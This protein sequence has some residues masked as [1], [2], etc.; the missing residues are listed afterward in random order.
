MESTRRHRF[1]C[2]NIFSEGWYN[3]DI[4][5]L[6]DWASSSAMGKGKF[7]QV[8]ETSNLCTIHKSNVTWRNLDHV[9][10]GL[11]LQAIFGLHA[12]DSVLNPPRSG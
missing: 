11:S 5:K 7:S 10:F 1:N 6:C 3:E 4:V 9:S 2:V 12:K 8:R